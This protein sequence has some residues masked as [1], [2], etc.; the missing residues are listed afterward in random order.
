M[1]QFLRNLSVVYAYNVRTMERVKEIVKD[2][3]TASVKEK[4]KVIIPIYTPTLADR[5][6][7]SVRQTLS[8]LGRYPMAL[9]VPDDMATDWYEANF[10]Q[11]ERIAV[12]SEWLGPRNGIEGYNRMMLSREFYQIFSDYEYI[13][14]CQSDAWI[15]RDE[16]EQWCDRSFDYVAAPWPK[17]RVYDLPVV[18]H[19]LKLR[20]WLWRDPT[21]IIRQQ[22]FNKVGN[23]GL[24]LRRVE[25]FICSCE[26]HSEVIEIFKHRSGML[27]NEDWFW[28][29]IPSE[30]NY[31]SF[32]EAL[33]F[34]FDI[35]PQM[36]YTLAG[37]RLPF[38]CH[39][40]Y[41]PRNLKFW[42]PIIE[43]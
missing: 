7:R 38:G 3:V 21:R 14:I 4:V 41:K 31:P 15:F 28:S 43:Q 8:I 5:A 6:E 32:D 17:R 25:A 13:L 9:L 33:G 26:R 2:R 35:R 42:Q 11:I 37:E 30:L 40:W 36:C 22:G 20:R 19:W 34:S 12:S 18:R 24:S 39:G 27:Y 23:G 1:E 10:P 29:I 16:L